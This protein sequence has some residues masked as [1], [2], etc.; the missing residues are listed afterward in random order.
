MH[1]AGTIFALSSGGGRAGIAVIRLSG[2]GVRE[3]VARIAG[4]LPEPRRASVRTLRDP[5][6]GEIV[7]SGLLLF[8]AGPASFTGEDL[9]EFQVHGSPAVVRRLLTLLAAQPDCAMAEAGAFSRRA[10]QNGKLD[11]VDVETLADL[12]AAETDLQRRMALRGGDD[13]RRLAQ[14]WRGRLL[15]L[16]A[17][18]EAEID[19]G[20]EGDVAARLDSQTEQSCNGL[21]SEL[22]AAADQAKVS[23]RLREGFRV[24]I[25]GPPNAGKSSLL[26]ALARRDVAIVTDRPG[27]TRDVLEVALDLDGVPVIISDAAGIRDSADMIEQEGVRRAWQSAG[28]ADMVLWANPVDSPAERP[29]Q[30]FF[31]VRTKSDLNTGIAGSAISTV[32]G[33]GIADLVAMLRKRALA[34]TEGLVSGTMVR[35]ARQAGAL[36]RAAEALRSAADAGAQTLDL[37]GEELRRACDCLDEFVGRVHHEQV[38]DEIFARFCIGK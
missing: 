17:R 22:E 27:T 8:F 33:H 13:M 12:I 6:S 4:P 18:V 9:A 24:A 19:F 14:C 1:Q 35:T 23:E 29:D 36:R 32:S 31:E 15:D 26:N 7:D 2:P 16:R 5:A 37:R 38:L 34:G 10:L 30:R 20:D 25:L 11:L 21:A 3:I 28:S